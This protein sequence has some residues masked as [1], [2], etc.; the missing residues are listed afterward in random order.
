MDKYHKWKVLLIILL[1]ALAIWKSNPLEEK[2]NMGLD[3]QGG[4]QLLLQVQLD[5]VPIENRDDATDRVVK[6]IR[7]RIDEFGV[8]EPVISKQGRDQVVIQLPGVTDRER[9]RQIAGKTAHLEFKLVSDDAEL[10]KKAEA[11]NVPENYE[12]KSEK[13]PTG[14]TQP[15][16]LHKQA[17]MSGDRLVNAA[18]SFDNYGQAIVEIEFDKEGAKIFDQATF[19][20]IGRRLAIVLDGVVYSAPVIR[21]R[22]P[23][24]RGQISG[25]FTSDEAGDLALVLRAGA[26]PAPVKIIEERSVGA[27]LG[28]DSIEKGIKAGLAAAV[29]IFFFMPVYYLLA[30]FIA[31]LGLMIYSILVI[32]TMALLGSSLTLPGIA[33]FIL[34]IGM[35]VDA[36]VLIYERIREEIEI[37]KTP[38]AAIAAGYHRAFSAIVDSNVTTLITSILLFAFG[39]GPIKGFAITLT[40]GLIASLFSAL[41]VTRVVFDFVSSRN[42]NVNL[43]MRKWIGVTHIRFLKGRWLAYGFSAITLVIGVTTIFMRGTENFGV[44]FTGGT[45]VQI[46]F[47]KQ[48]EIGDLRTALQKVGIGESSIQKY[49]EDADHQFVI[50]S[51]SADT[52]KIQQAAKSVSADAQILRVDEVGPAVSSDLKNKALWAVFWS[53]MGILV[54]LAIRFEWKFAASAVVALFHDAIFTFGVY[55]LSG[56][57]INLPIVAAIL[58]IMGFSVNDTI[59]TFD[60]VRENL[61]TVR[62][63]SFSE[64][65]EL[66]INQTLARTLLTGLTVLFGA[67]ALFFFGGPG[68]ND[69]AF[70]LCIGFVVGTYSTIFVANSVLVDWKA[71]RI[72]SQ[73]SA[74]SKGK[75]PPAKNQ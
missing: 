14:M 1:T 24:G 16:L 58:T 19:Q 25:N 3:L 27:T 41:I 39:T 33:G 48:V 72:P 47:Q 18:V 36:N 5:Q 13:S 12:L 59:V 17:L 8:K 73:A 43:K 32:G 21:D 54:Y 37:G 67:L 57:E 65:V 34:S 64:I 44:E 50:R 23:G 69:F 6:I 60:R 63:K 2:I 22:I 30:G 10:L 31:D 52:E 74:G 61:K 29:L 66:S 49:G 56:R 35:A 68:I 11:G 75:V 28:R 40:L 71:V 53:S 62:K 7:T 4:M 51:K 20:N 26:L 9:A 55:A 38:R 15:L 46:G 45:M 42:P 70:I